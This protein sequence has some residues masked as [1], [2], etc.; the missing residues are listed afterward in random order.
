MAPF[1]PIPSTRMPAAPPSPTRLDRIFAAPGGGTE[2]PPAL[3]PF[4]TGGFPSMEATGRLVA[5]MAQAGARAIEIGFP[6]SD[7]IAD[8]PVIARSMA[9]AL[10][11]GA[12]PE[13]IFELVRTL[14]P[15]TSVGLL[16]MVSC[17]IVE[18][19]GV[20]RFIEEAAASGFDG[21]IVPDLDLDGA[22]AY[23]DACAAHE[24]AF[25]VLAGPM[26]S[27]QRLERIAA[28]CSGFLYVLARVGLT[29]ERGMLPADLPQRI[30]LLRQLTPLPLC[31]GFGI[32]DAAQVRAVLELAD[33]AIVGSAVVRRIAEA[34]ARGDDPAVVAG[35]FIAELVGGVRGVGAS[36]EGSPRS[37][38]QPLRRSATSVSEHLA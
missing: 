13:K 33:A 35:E 37:H 12:T 19:M 32:S 14:R 31:V 27:P 1:R 36:S 16:A 10:R 20:R 38:A 29:G 2:R 30:S 21:L 7:P 25:S 4:I 5:S 11:G 15:S 3:M 24:L 18:R 28:V 22:P 26:S 17:S 6:F 34:A 8:G 9:E 23:R